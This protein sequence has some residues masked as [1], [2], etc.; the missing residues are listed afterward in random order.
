[1]GIIA[2]ASKPFTDASLPA[3]AKIVSG[4][5]ADVILS[6]ARSDDYDMIIMG[7]IGAGGGFIK[8]V[9]LGLGSVAQKVLA[10][11]P[12]PVLVVKKETERT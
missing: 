12:C 1:M 4:H 2:R 10:N 7:S 6:E 11:A 8:R 5:A 3:E 9:V